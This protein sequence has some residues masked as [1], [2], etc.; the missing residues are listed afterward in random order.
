MPPS[1]NTGLSQPAV[2]APS[3]VAS[4][5]YFPNSSL[6]QLDSALVNSTPGRALSD[7]V[8]VVLRRRS[9]WTCIELR[10]SDLSLP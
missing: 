4:T 2:S 9:P 8:A 3:L 10:G 1:L 7:L 6:H 5:T